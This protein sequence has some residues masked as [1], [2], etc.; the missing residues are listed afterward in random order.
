M[1]RSP[2][3]MF[4][5]ATLL[6]ALAFTSA[7][8][9][10]LL[11]A[12]VPL[13]PAP[14][15]EPLERLWP[16][17]T[18][19]S[20]Q[21]LDTLSLETKVAQLFVTHANGTREG[22][23]GAEWRRLTD[24]VENFRVGGVVFFRGEA[25][26]QAQAIQALQER[27][28][29]P[30]LVAQDME[31]GTGMR[32]DG[33]TS[34]PWPMALGA[35]RS[36]ELAYRMGR[37][38]AEEARAMGVHQNYAPVADINNNAANP[39]INVR[40]FGERAGLV[41]ALTTA[42]LRG[43]QDGGLLATV[44]HFPGHGDTATDSHSDLPTLPFSRPR[45]DTLELE[46]FRAAVDAGVMSVMTGHLF[47]PQLDPERAATTSPRI[48]TGLLRDELGFDG[49]VIT[50]GLDMRGVRQGQSIGEVAVRALEAG[51][52]QLILTRDEY[53]ARESVLDA[54]RQ[55]RL[56]EDR[57]DASVERIL[58]AKAWAGL[59]DPLA[60]RPIPPALLPPEQPELR[61]AVADSIRDA[62]ALRRAQ[63]AELAAPSAELT[64][65]ADGLARIIA[66]NAVTLVQ[67]PDGP[68][69]FVGPGAPS[70][71]L[72]LI[73]DDSEN[74]A[75]GE[76]FAGA[77]AAMIPPGGRAT[78]RRLGLGDRESLFDE[79]FA[80]AATH[81]IIL[82]A[83]FVRV[84]SWSGEIELPARHKRFVA[85]LMATGKPVV[86]LAFGN[87][88]VPLGLP[89]PAAFLA[90]YSTTPA[91][92]RAAGEALFGQIGVTGRL[93]VSIPGHYRFGEGAQLDQQVLRLGTPEEAGLA[94]EV[95]TRLDAVMEDA[96]R[97]R[98]FPGAALAVGRGGVLV[99]LRGYGHFTYAGV[100]RV[101]AQ[102]PYD[103]ASLT[104]VIATTSA[105]M[106]LVE[107]GHLDLDAPVARYLPAFGQ[108]GKERVTIRHLLAHSAGQR[109]FYPFH[110][111]DVVPDREGIL[112]FIYA[113][114]I[115]Y[116]PGTRTVYSDFDMI[117]LGE[118]IETITGEPLDRYVDETIFRPL[119]MTATGFR[120]TGRRDITVAPTETDRRFRGRTLQGEVHDEAAWLMGGISGHAGLFS[121]ASDLS[122]MAYV[123]ANGGEGYGVRLFE[124]ETLEQFTERISSR[125]RYPMAL[126]WMSWRP[127]SE[128]SSSAGRLFGPSSF[129]HTGFTGTSIWIDPEEEL[130]VI[131]LSN[132]VHPTRRNGRISRVRPALADGA[133]GSIRTEAG[134]PER[135]LG[136]GTP[137]DD[138]MRP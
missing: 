116:R 38:I 132:R 58:R 10:A 120:S 47:L 125:G 32:V 78:H 95:L 28:P 64:R 62:R 16:G 76:D 52:D 94:P 98:A 5:L 11:R 56:T 74:E 49:L 48:I 134:H 59:A 67:A 25:T 117:V 41:S 21:V 85:R 36:P 71:F 103:L 126:G 37:A 86:L 54:V 51:A 31:F 77:V 121:T 43:M 26:T 100:D 92:Q 73:L 111:D 133:A 13:S 108:R 1:A 9:I 55:G 15:V 20:A 91:S 96:L 53:E 23:T 6:V 107:E 46:P 27:A 80:Q 109:A 75:T 22:T 4:K 72:T 123:L 110:T 57:I 118:V 45:L 14:P 106:K 87:P 102:T 61:D 33:G 137:P 35:T 131:L 12:P 18:A 138:L 8:G 68:V 42:T 115:R 44:K 93:P 70:R 122:R 34:F 69:P 119:G 128:G 124:R 29:I 82:A 17:T 3:F 50:D 60:G 24:L 79:A 89:E 84:R 101:T 7:T 39:I 99:R 113:D 104:K 97:D 129:G 30:L 40:S 83:T 66:R 114:S 2:A 127:A 81:E 130:F 136:F 135:L 88:Y 90:T 65:R 105:A 19:W 63:F 112:D